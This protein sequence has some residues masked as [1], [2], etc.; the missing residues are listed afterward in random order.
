MYDD[1]WQFVPNDESALMAE[2]TFDASE[3]GWLIKDMREKDAIVEQIN[4][5]LLSLARG[6]VRRISETIDL[7]GNGFHD[8]HFGLI[9]ERWCEYRLSPKSSRYL[10]SNERGG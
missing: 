5:Y 7:V 3:G 10:S 1:A 4:D 9:S 8:E 6:H 2:M